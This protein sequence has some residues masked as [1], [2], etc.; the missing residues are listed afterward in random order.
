MPNPQCVRIIIL[1]MYFGA[2][3]L[4]ILVK[5]INTLLN[6]ISSLNFLSKNNL[7]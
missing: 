7:H 5:N 6:L 2:W 3:A 1:D 4:L